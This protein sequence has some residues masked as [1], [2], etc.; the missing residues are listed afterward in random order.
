MHMIGPADTVYLVIIPRP[1]HPS[2]GPDDWEDMIGVAR[3]TDQL[4]NIFRGTLPEYARK[5]DYYLT[6]DFDQAVAVVLNYFPELYDRDF[7][8]YR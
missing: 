7:D 1:G 5:E 4:G 2:M 3:G 8:Q 6:D